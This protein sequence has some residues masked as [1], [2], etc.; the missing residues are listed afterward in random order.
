MKGYFTEDERRFVS[1]M[2]SNLWK[3]YK[4]EVDKPD[5]SEEKM[6]ELTKLWMFPY[7]SSEMLMLA[8]LNSIPKGA[9]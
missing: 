3:G 7:L 4:Q 9:P 8:L 6:E 1:W 5:F 2:V